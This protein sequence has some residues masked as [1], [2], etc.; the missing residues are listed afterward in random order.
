MNYFFVF[1]N[2]SYDKERR[3]SYLWAPK[4]NAKGQTKSHWTSMAQVKKGD[5]IMHSCNKKIAAIS[6]ASRD[7]EDG[8]Q[9]TE[10]QKEDLWHND[11]YIV[12]T[13]YYTLEHSIIT[14]DFKDEIYDMQP[15]QYGPFNSLKRGNTGYLFYA[16]KALSKFLLNEIIKVQSDPDIIK[17]IKE[18]MSK[19]GL[20]DDRLEKDVLDDEDIIDVLAEV[21][22]IDA[23]IVGRG[24]TGEAQSKKELKENLK[25]QKKYPR[26]PKVAANA[27]AIAEHKCEVD[28]EHKVFKRR[29]SKYYYTEPHH[30]VPLSTHEKFDVS[31]DVEEN[32]VS[33]CSY[34]HNLLHYGA[35][36]EEILKRLYEERKSL[37]EGVGIVITYEELRNLY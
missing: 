25:G 7:C 10:L 28:K 20:L 8:E 2:K 32:I 31:L 15:A 37:L 13:D 4:A 27:L 14:S 1:Q 3:G 22:D 26:C 23:A 5:L 9:P 24:Y 36:F 18:I 16:G 29:N 11:G 17:D 35:D 12:Y 21:E 33:L 34:C 30:L 19:T 6:I